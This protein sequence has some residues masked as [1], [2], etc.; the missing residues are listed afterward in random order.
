MADRQI[1]L[2]GK[3]VERRELVDSSG[4]SMGVLEYDPG[5]IG[6]LSRYLEFEQRVNAPEFVELIERVDR[7]REENPTEN[8]KEI[9]RLITEIENNIADAIDYLFKINSR[10]TCFSVKSPLWIHRIEI[11]S[12]VDEAYWFQRIMNAAKLV[13]REINEKRLAEKINRIET[14]TAEFS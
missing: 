8:A 9:A 12:G 2:G 3:S 5:D 13:M 14:A 7:L 4:N 6:I 10:A 11:E 1:I